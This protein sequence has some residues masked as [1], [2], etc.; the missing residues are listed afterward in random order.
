M[1]GVQDHS[2]GQEVFLLDVLEA[3][4]TEEGPI[5]VTSD[6]LLETLVE[7]GNQVAC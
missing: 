7:L 6:K 2:K 5:E 4:Q 1:G 3:M